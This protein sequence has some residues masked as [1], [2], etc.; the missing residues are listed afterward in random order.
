MSTT[1]NSQ[2]YHKSTNSAEV[3]QVDQDNKVYL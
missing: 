2:V 1:L 3:L